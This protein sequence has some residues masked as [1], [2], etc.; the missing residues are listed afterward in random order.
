VAQ[1][2]SLRTEEKFKKTEVGEI[3]VDW[4]AMRLSEIGE[5]ITG[6]TPST[7]NRDYYNGKYMFVTP[8]DMG[9]FKYVTKTAIMLSEAGMSV[10]KS[11]PRNTVMVTCIASIGKI[12]MASAKCCTNQQINSVICQ[13]STDSHF[14]YYVMQTK[15]NTLKAL[16]GQTA[17]PIVK[18][19]LF[20]NIP[21]PLPSLSE[22][23]KITEILSTVDQAVEK[24][25]E[26]I[27]KTKKL[28]KGLIQE[29]L[30]RGIGHKK[31][32]KT[33]IGEI[34]VEWEIVE[35]RDVCRRPEY[36]YTQRATDKSIGPRFLR[37]TDIQH[38]RVVWNNVPY[39][40]CSDCV[41]D[42]YILRPGDILFARTGATTGKSYLIKDCPEAVVASYLIRIVTKEKIGCVFLYLVFNSFIYWRQIKQQMGGSAQG[43]VNASLLSNL[44]IPL[45]SLSE[46]NKIAEILSSVNDEIEKE[47]KQKESL[48]ILKKGLMKVLL[49]GK[50]RVKV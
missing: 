15:I 19:S 5:I 32:K 10:S 48:E 11:L 43:G 17:V 9:D 46:Q 29:L 37:I 36:G 1:I 44:K 25:N 30:T 31:F 47:M 21:I 14:V 12:A 20:S 39:C 49:T 13:K 50:T 23:K 24:S 28:K 38:G 45:P 41:K 33:E 18:K 6:S 8:F 22:Q 2:D 34:P 26:I 40:E 35:V 4:G 16:A 7:K 42:K 3:P 27:E